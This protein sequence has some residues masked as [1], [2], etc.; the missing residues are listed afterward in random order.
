MDLRISLCAWLFLAACSGVPTDLPEGWR[1]PTDAELDGQSL[2]K[3]SNWKYARATGDFDG[4]GVD[5]TAYLLKSETASG[6]GLW[7]RLS[8]HRSDDWRVLDEIH[9]GEQYPDASLAMGIETVPPGKYESACGKGYWDCAS[10]EPAAIDVETAA[11]RYFMFDSASSV[12]H[13]DAET[14]VFKRTWTSD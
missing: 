12:F 2:R 14:G 10:D 13:W 5:D 1:F 7:V 9:W 6:Q 11:L 3:D 4:D 8:S